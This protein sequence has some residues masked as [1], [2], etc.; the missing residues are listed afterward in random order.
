MGTEKR[1]EQV[2]VSETPFWGKGR[3]MLTGS[4]WQTT[5]PKQ[6]WNPKLPMWLIHK[7]HCQERTQQG[8][9]EE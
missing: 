1:K 9:K 6:I 4:K 7:E 3:G 8:G 2:A 5:K